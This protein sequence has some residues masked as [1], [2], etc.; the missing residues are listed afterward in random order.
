MERQHA[1]HRTILVVDV[2]GFGAPHRANR[3]RVAVRQG[4]NS[5][6]QRAFNSA[7]ISWDSCYIEGTGDGALVLAPAEMPK[8]PF[9]DVVPLALVTALRQHNSTHSVEEQIRLRMAL[10]AGEV[11]LDEHGVTAAAVNLTFRLLDAAPLKE[12]LAASSGVLALITS[13]WFFDEVVRHS[14]NVES[15]T[16]RPVQVSVKET[17]TTAWISLPDHPYPSDA[18]VLTGLAGHTAGRPRRQFRLALQSRVSRLGMSTLL[19]V[20]TGVLVNV[21]TSQWVWSAGAGFLM[22]IVAWVG[23]GVLRVGRSRVVASWVG[24]GGASRDGDVKGRRRPWMGPPLDR[25][26]ER[27]ELGVRLLA[28]LIAPEPTEVGMTTGLR[29]AGGFGKTILAAWVC[30]RPE[31]SLRYP[32]G[33][34]WV[35]VG[36][37]VHGADLAERINDLACV[38]SGQRPALTNPNV[39]GAELGRL[40]DELGEPV[41]LV[42]DDVWEEPQLRPFRYGGRNCS[43]LVTTRIPELLPASASTI[44]VDAMSAVQA[45][46][47]LSDGLVAFPVDVAERLAVVAGRWPVLLNLLNGVLRRRVQRGQPVQ[48]A[49]AEVLR[50]LVADGP[51]AFDPTRPAERTE[52]VAATVEASMILLESSDRRCYLALAIFP[53]DVDIPKDVLGLLWPDAKVDRLCEELVGLGLAADYRL[54]APGPR[55]ILHDVIRAYLL[56]CQTAADRAEVHRRLITAASAL[57][58]GAAEIGLRPWWTLPVDAEY[59]WR[60][61]PQHLAAAGELDELTALVCDLRWVEAKDSQDWLCGRC[62]G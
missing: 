44:T 14:R 30:H 49:A 9:V 60:Y 27:P 29:G 24:P 25:M 57:L 36:Q 33:L 5:A 18:R 15:A 1:V 41:L 50:T 16:F 4:L 2:E 51:V 53:E 37:E 21:A 10:H 62:H 59:L 17:T 52:A 39:A 3:H 13:G 19:A 54:D 58:G 45:R 34:L 46:Q 28:S 20:G 55:L 35:S 26:V 12:A 7:G 47:L 8:A 22:W 42:V 48:E 11:E 6:L 43:R 61:L 31:I 23:F 32:G 40:L 38:L 56:S